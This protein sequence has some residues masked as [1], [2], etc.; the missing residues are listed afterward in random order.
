[1]RFSIQSILGSGQPTSQSTSMIDNNLQLPAET[2]AETSRSTASVAMI[3]SQQAINSSR[4]TTLKDTCMVSDNKVKTRYDKRKESRARYAASD[5]GKKVRARYEASDKGKKTRARARAKY[6]ASEKGKAA[7]LR[8]STKYIASD[9]FRES[10][11]KYDASD[12]GKMCR[13]LRDA[14]SNTYKTAKEKGLSE[15]L[16]RKKADLAAQA[17][18]RK[19]NIHQSLP[20]RVSI[21]K[22]KEYLQSRLKPS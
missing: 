9:K 4:A 3:N 18:A 6:N 2:S 21:I 14:R 12:R 13:R 5:K 17:R 20:P 22:L 10:R 11:A 1:E 7:R 19:L 8:A 15:V 16:A